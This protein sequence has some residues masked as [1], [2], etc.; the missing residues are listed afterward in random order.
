[1]VFAGF[2]YLVYVAF[3]ALNAV[4][5]IFNFFAIEIFL[6]VALVSVTFCFYMPI[7]IGDLGF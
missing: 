4:F 7:Q 5:F 6:I 3:Q 1:M 2:S